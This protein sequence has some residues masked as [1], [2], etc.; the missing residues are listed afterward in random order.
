MAVIQISKI[1]V[2]RGKKVS[3]TGV[4]QLSSAEFAWAIDSQELFIGNGSVAEGAPYVGNTKILTEHDNILELAAAYRFASTDPSIIY[5]EPRSLQGKLDE[6]VSV[7]DFGAVNDGSTDC[8]A[9][10]QNAFL[11]LF[12]N[13][14]PN[15]KKVLL[16]PNGEYLFLSNLRIP[17]TAIIRGETQNGAVLNIGSND[18]L[19]IT[20]AGDDISTSVTSVTRPK[21]VDISNLT[22]SRTSGQVT[23]TGLGDS[24]FSNVTFKGE[25]VIPAI[26]I[27]TSPLSLSAALFWENSIIDIQVDNVTFDQCVFENNTISLKCVQSFPTE[28]KLYFNGC[29]FIENDI[30]VYINGDPDQSNAWAFF[31][32]SFE[33][34][35][36]Q[37]FWSTQGFNT[38]FDSC[39]FKNCGNGL[40]DSATPKYPVVEFG[41]TRNNRLINCSTNRIQAIGD[42]T[43]LTA[44]GYSEAVNASLAQFTDRNYSTIYKTDSAK[45]LA[46]FSTSN[47]YFY[48]HYTLK[49]N[50]NPGWVA[51]P[52]NPVPDRYTRVG[53][54]TITIDDD[55]T[56]TSITDEYQY[57]PFLTTDRGGIMMTSFDFTV[58]IKSRSGDST[59]ETVVLSYV[60]PVDRGSPGIISYHVT[61]GA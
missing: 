48:V 26:D 28:T 15:Y 6:Y 2:R 32:C 19:F 4:P 52:S 61:Y 59:E 40:G 45:P 54:L 22:I 16:V 49:L 8:T 13:T 57:S 12:R 43:T 55:H 37:A 3:N 5:S 33:L 44:T 7:A 42:A 60:N 47:R 10:F 20:E 23:L 46:L 14:N 38:L 18:I 11:E 24:K 50:A 21:N 29:K 36:K 25:Y 58:D 9:A 34:I 1:Q 56:N 27:T 53:K 41:Q 17:S 51:S 31:D 35:A 39:D 30:G